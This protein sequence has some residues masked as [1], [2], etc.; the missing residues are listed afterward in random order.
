[1]VLDNTDQRSSDERL[2]FAQSVIVEK[3]SAGRKDEEAVGEERER[4]GR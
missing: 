1:M 2:K 4:L 3:I